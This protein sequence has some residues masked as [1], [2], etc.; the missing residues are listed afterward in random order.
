MRAIEL[1]IFDLDGTLIDSAE[2]IAIHVSKV[3]KELKG[4]TVSFEEV[5]KNIGDGA[6]SLLLNFFDP[7]E[8]EQALERFLFYYRAEPVLNTRPYEGIMETL[9]KLR[10]RKVLL[11]V[12]T[13]KPHDITL[14]VL[15]A[16]G[17]MEFFHEVVGADLLP[18]K[19]PSPMPLLEIARRLGVETTRA[20]MVGDS[21]VDIEAGRRANMQTAYASW[22]YKIPEITPD[23]TLKHPRQ[24]L[25][26]V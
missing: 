18:E 19:K 13:N 9:E 25:E 11:A 1:V 23:Y 16:L 14:D 22:G 4:R 8:L 12:A 26:L 3:L 15:K 5:K 17:M 6:R 10:K 2:D 24:I 21:H 7:E 20:L